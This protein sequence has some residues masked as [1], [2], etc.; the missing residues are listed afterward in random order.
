MTRARWGGLLL[1]LLCGGISIFWGAVLVRVVPG[2]PLDFQ[3]IYYGTRCLLQHHNPY[4]ESEL[5]SVYRA[6][7]GERPSESIQARRIVTFYRNLPPTFLFITP[8]AMLPLGAAEALWMILTGGVF[9]LA[10]FLMWEIGAS[11]APGVSLLLICILLAN[12]EVLFG[13]GNTAG[14][15]VSLCVVAVWCFLQERFVPAGILCMAASLAIK[16]HDA[17][18]VWLFFLLAGGVYRKRA[19][20]TLAVTVVLGVA[21]IL[22][23]SHVAPH[24]MQGLHANLMATSVHGD[25]NDPGPDS[26]TGRSVS[27]IIDLQAAVSV[28][29]DDPRIYNPASYLVCGALMLAWSVRTLRSRFLQARAWLALAAIVPLTML[30]TY[31]RSYDAKL[32]LLTVPA[33]AMLWAE[34]GQIGWIALLATTAGI[35]LTADIPLTILMILTKNLRI[36][37]VG[38]PGQILTV[39]LT[40]PVPLILLAMG[41]IYLWVYV[42]R[43]NSDRESGT[44]FKRSEMTAVHDKLVEDDH[45]IRITERK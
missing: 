26:V 28:F 16:P 29:R 8:L 13:S 33:C 19:L 24:W 14:I 37:T 12:A 36:S 25:L 27:M 45:G 43:A 23:V 5:E 40:R 21:S 4:I 3:H 9:I 2:G 30:V 1:L 41:I 34:G 31:H 11:Y 6:E 38:L 17:G 39:V 10:A 32:L 35:V 44:L 22:W 18:L 7:G 20:Q 15:V 42:R